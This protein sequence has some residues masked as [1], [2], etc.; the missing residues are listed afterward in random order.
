MDQHTPYTWK[1]SEVLLHSHDSSLLADYEHLL[2]PQ[3]CCCTAVLFRIL[4]LLPWQQNASCLISPKL[5]SST[6]KVGQLDHIGCLHTSKVPVHVALSSIS[7]NLAP[8]NPPPQ[9]YLSTHAT[10]THRKTNNN[11]YTWWNKRHR[12]WKMQN[13]I[14]CSTLLTILLGKI[15]YSFTVYSWNCNNQ[16]FQT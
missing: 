1:T 8:A 4:N 7:L 14:R 5:W 6:G 15:S 12:T 3:N 16:N 13:I 10:Q 9:N 11:S 2:W